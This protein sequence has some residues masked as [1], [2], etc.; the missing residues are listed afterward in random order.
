MG[1]RQGRARQARRDHSA[2]ESQRGS[3]GSPLKEY[4]EYDSDATPVQTAA[5]TPTTYHLPPTTSPDCR[6]QYSD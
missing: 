1:G 5:P 6:K 3:K 4:K 2:A